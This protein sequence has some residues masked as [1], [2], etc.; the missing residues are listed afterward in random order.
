MVEP[1]ARRSTAA[2]TL[3]REQIIDRL[4]ELQSGDLP[5][6]GGHTLAYVYDSGLADADEVGR[7]ALTMFAA[8]NGLDPTAFP[9][10]LTMERELVAVGRHVLHGSTTAVGTVTS[11]GTESILLAVQAA[12][13]A[14]EHISRPAMIVPSTIHAAFAKA[15]HYLRVERIVVPV[16]PVTHRADV[17]AMTA[18]VEQNVDRLVLVAASAPSYAHGVVDP[19]GQL[20]AVAQ[21]HG[22]RFH[23]DAC[24]GGWVLPWAEQ[25]GRPVEPWDFRVPGVTSVSV[26][27]HKYAYTPKGVSLLLHSTPR[28]RHSQFFASADWPGYTMLN[29][30]MQSTKSGGPLAAAWAVVHHIGLDGYR[31]LVAATLTG[32]DDLVRG[33]ADL[34]ELSVVAAP[35]SSLVAVRADDSCDVFTISDEML[36][37]G[38]FVQPQMSFRDDPPSLHFTLCAATA[39]SVPAL[40]DALRDAIRAAVEAGPVTIDDDLRAAAGAL[41]PATLDDEQFD[42][43]L[44]LA[45]LGGDPDSPESGTVA[46]PD[47][48]APVNAL[49]DVAPPA[50]RE[51]LLIAFL[52]RLTR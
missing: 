35:D 38:W 23:V 13:D 52:D 46:L 48:M 39:A 18:A 50:L 31:D 41:D 7:E 26:D 24:I 51:A 1:E 6:H 36:R 34:P 32:T 14:A 29:S 21:Q 10:L 49:L 27:L 16:D 37:R 42:Q 4:T 43:L 19:I 44:V 3:T 17:A 12:R 33:L 20:A 5:T 15:A 9:S 8:S 45:G 28:G 2:H 40:L 47:A 11:G 30:T 25:L 22:V